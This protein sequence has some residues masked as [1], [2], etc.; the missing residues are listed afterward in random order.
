M[1]KNIRYI[2]LAILV[3]GLTGGAYGWY[4]YQ[5]PSSKV[6]TSDADLKI[7]AADLFKDLDEGGSTALQ[8]Y[9]GKVVL[10]NGEVAS[11]QNDKG[12]NLN[13]SLM[14]EE[15]SPFGVTGEFAPGY[16]AELTKI[17]EGEII[18]FKGKVSG[19]L[20]LGD[21]IISHA[22]LVKE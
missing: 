11:I 2:L 19:K 7:S 17:H 5:K 13:I 18:S 10:V 6:T 4:L 15:E 20:S 9:N 14:A 8:K 21:V 22:S 1:K 12:G 3:I 16:P